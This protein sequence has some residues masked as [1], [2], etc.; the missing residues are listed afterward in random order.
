MKQKL[1]PVYHLAD[2]P[3]FATDEECA[4]FWD[5]HEFT[6]EYLAEARDRGETPQRPADRLTAAQRAK[7][8]A[9]RV[10]AGI[11]KERRAQAPHR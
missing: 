7:D 11:G 8:R 5:M 6:E 1:V 3:D 4:A 9:A 2:V 10:S